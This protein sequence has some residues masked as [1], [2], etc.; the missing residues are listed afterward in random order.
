MLPGFRQEAAM[1]RAIHK[2]KVRQVETLSTPGRYSDGGNLY[3]VVSPS[4]SR[5]WVFLYRD[6]DK[7]KDEKGRSK[8]RELG[9]G[10]AA[11]GAVSLLDA[12]AMAQKA[13]DQ[14]AQG[15]NPHK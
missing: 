8:S 9:L 5:K 1:V 14:L 12:C 2:L 10:S 15:F 6:E 13:R 7:G 3:L 11:K 4:G